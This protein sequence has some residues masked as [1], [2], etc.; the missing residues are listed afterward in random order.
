MVFT[1][2][3]H[4]RLARLSRDLAA[5]E[6]FRVGGLGLGVLFRAEAG[7]AP[8][9]HDLLMAGLPDASRHLELVHGGDRPGSTPD[10]SADGA[11]ES[12]E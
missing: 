11:R 2:Q 1:G 5:A 12:D 7:R 4:V 8:G 10:G 9:A 3:S 6:R